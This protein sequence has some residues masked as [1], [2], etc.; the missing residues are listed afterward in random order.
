MRAAQLLLLMSVP[1][2]MIYFVTIRLLKPS[3]VYVTLPFITF[4]LLVACLQVFVLLYFAYILVPYCW[5]KAID[6][7]NA[8]IPMIM[9]IGDL[10]GTLLL[11]AAYLIL[12]RL[13]DPNVPELL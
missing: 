8:A 5:S 13:R 11:T 6:P 1:G 10:L 9:A 2:H 3:E 4:Y 7:D 12:H